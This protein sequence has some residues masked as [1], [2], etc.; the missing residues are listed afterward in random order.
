MSYKLPGC[1]WDRKKADS[2]V[3]CMLLFYSQLCAVSGSYRAEAD[4]GSWPRHGTRL[5]MCLEVFFQSLIT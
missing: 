3:G 5:R 2:H 4:L 1:A